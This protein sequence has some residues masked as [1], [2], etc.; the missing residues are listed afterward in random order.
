MTKH[1]IAIDFG[2][3]KLRI[4]DHALGMVFNQPAKIATTKHAG[5]FHVVAVGQNASQMQC[6]A[7]HIVF[8]PISAGVVQSAEY[9]SAFLKHALQQIYST[10]TL[11]KLCAF[12]ALPSGLD[13]TQKQE[14]VD[15]C[16]AACLEHIRITDGTFCTLLSAQNPKPQQ[17]ILVIDLGN[18]KCDFQLLCNN[19]IFKS[20]TLGIGSSAIAR[21][22][23]KHLWDEYNFYIDLP[24][25]QKLTETVATLSKSNI[26]STLLSGISTKNNQTTN[27]NIT[28]LMLHPIVLGFFEEIILIA[29][30]IVNDFLQEQPNQQIAILLGGG[31]ANMPNLKDFMRNKFPSHQITIHPNPENAVILGLEKIIT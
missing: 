26:N 14:Y 15:M 4:F 2:S 22:A 8:S 28:S 31:L 12:I 30:T 16:K 19:Q 21:A 25:A 27:K 6:Q 20:A 10:S 11:K 1:S 9:A 18:S 17:P 29:Q 7:Q 23:Q 5:K 24:Q 13:A 3:E